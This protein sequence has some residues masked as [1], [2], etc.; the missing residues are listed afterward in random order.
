MEARR[1]EQLG[2]KDANIRAKMASLHK[3]SCNNRMPYHH[4]PLIQI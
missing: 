1:Q 2:V 4:R 3:V